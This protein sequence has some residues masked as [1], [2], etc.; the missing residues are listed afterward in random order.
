MFRVINI[1]KK[2]QFLTVLFGVILVLIMVFGVKAYIERPQD[3]GA[4]LEYIGKTDYGCY[5][6]CDSNPA[7]VYYFATDMTQDELKGYFKNADYV[8]HPNSGGGGGAG[9]NFDD[10]YF[11][12][13]N[14]NDEFL[15]NYYDNTQNVLTTNRLK[16]TSKKSV[17]SMGSFYYLYAR[18]GL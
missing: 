13:R 1:Y 5:V 8:E 4:G 3:L 9:Y 18:E 11:K 10:L 17:V 6:F 14:G 16:Q 15:I 2:H 7:S 12:P